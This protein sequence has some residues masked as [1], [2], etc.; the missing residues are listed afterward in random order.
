VPRANGAAAAAAAGGVA[1]GN[2]VLS[3][4]FSTESTSNSSPSP[5]RSSSHDAPPTG[6]A[7]LGSAADDASDRSLAVHSIST[8]YS[9]RKKS[10]AKQAMLSP[11]T[12]PRSGRR[13]SRRSSAERN[14]A[15]AAAT[16]AVLD[17]MTAEPANGASRHGMS[18]QSQIAEQ[19]KKKLTRLQGSINKS[20]DP[21][22]LTTTMEASVDRLIEQSKVSWE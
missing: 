12:S 17:A 9:P 11:V 14:A 13:R 10:P 7:G 2:E 21:K 8:Q 15:D 22:R 16:A 18:L 3:I 20:A 6:V 1:L 5:G 19:A 4:A